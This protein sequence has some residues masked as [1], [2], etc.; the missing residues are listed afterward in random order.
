LIFALPNCSFCTEAIN[1]SRR[2][3]EANPTTGRVVVLLNAA[4]IDGYAD[5]EIEPNLLVTLIDSRDVLEVMRVRVGPFAYLVDH[6]VRVLAKGVLNSDA[7][8]ASLLATAGASDVVN[9][10]D[11]AQHSSKDPEVFVQ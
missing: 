11:T 4:S 10:V 1:A 7:D 8:L 5:V 2:W 6:Q 3:L 9:S